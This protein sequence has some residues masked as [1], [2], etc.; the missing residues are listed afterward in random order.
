M[1]LEHALDR[2][3]ARSACDHSD[4]PPVLHE[5]ERRH[6]VHMQALG[7]IGALL[8]VDPPHAQP[9]AFLA[10]HV[11]EQALHPTGRARAHA[12][13]EQQ[14]GAVVLHAALCLSRP[15]P[16]T[17]GRYPVTTL[18]LVGAWYTIGLSVGL[19]VALGV[20]FAGILGTSRV[21]GI[22]AGLLGAAAGI[23]AGLLV[24]GWLE[25]AGGA[26]GGALGALGAAQLVQGT[27]RRGGTRGG[28]AVFVA[29]GAII[30]GLLALV[31][32]VGYLEAVVLPALAARLR[33]R[34]GRT[35]SGLRILARD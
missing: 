27:R 19:G 24:D 29:L 26:I 8:D 14:E 3:G 1:G 2:R 23:A 20:L 30:L 25:A 11:S 22:V 28:T 21:G 10:R 17:N 34:R 35:F 16:R 7:Q 15:K 12:D 6:F 18:A 32:V 4:R 5:H 33:R 9:A 31:P 13:E